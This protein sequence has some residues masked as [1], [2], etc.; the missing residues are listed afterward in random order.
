MYSFAEKIFTP[1]ILFLLV[2][3]GAPTTVNIGGA[4]II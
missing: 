4:L 2:D 3:T 1:R